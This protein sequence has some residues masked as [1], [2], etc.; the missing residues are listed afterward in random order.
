MSV[1]FNDLDKEFW[2]YLLGRFVPHSFFHAVLSKHAPNKKDPVCVQ[3]RAFGTP[4]PPAI[5]VL[6]H[7][8]M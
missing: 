6:I 1:H 2:K 5:V 3:F 4:C 8:H 7:I